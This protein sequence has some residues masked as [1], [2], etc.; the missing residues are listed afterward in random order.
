MATAQFSPNNDAVQL[1]V[2]VAAPPA[3]VFQAITDPS[4]L[5]Q[6]W[7]Q[8]GLY[9]VTNA[10]S[11]LR[12]GGA[13]STSGV[14]EDGTEF[15]VKGEY[16]EVD[17]PRLLVQTW[18]PSYLGVARNCRAMGTRGTGGSRP[19]RRHPTPLRNWHPGYDSPLGFAGNVE[20]CKQHGDGWVRVLGWMQAFVEQDWG[21]GRGD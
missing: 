15:T 13:W 16:V 11:D 19:A 3:R 7:G 14:G 20:A 5:Q 8:K 17:P 2:F 1:E 10:H 18:N 4:Q 12:K 9:R 21:V 6:W